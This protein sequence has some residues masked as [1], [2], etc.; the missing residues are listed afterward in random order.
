MDADSMKWGSNARRRWPRSK[1][2]GDGRFAVLTCAFMHPSA[3]QMV[4]SDVHLFHTLEEAKASTVYCH[5][6]TKG[7]CSGRHEIV[8]LENWKRK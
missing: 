5:A 3:R 4:Y 1:V 7:L 6:S 8:D 2:H